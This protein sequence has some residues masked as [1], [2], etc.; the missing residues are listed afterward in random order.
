MSGVLQ[1]GSNWKR[2]RTRSGT[3][4]LICSLFFWP[5]ACRPPE[6]VRIAV[7]PQTE[8]TIHWD[9]AHAGAVFAADRAGASIYW[10][11]PTS[12]DDVQAQIALVNQVIDN[13]YQGLVLAPDQSLA[14]ITPVHRALAR[15]IPTVIIGSPLSIPAGR[16][17]FY[18]LN[19]DTEGGQIAAQRVADLLKGHGTVAVLGI[20]PNIAGIMIRARSF[21]QYLA[22]NFPEIHIVDKRIGTFNVAHEHQEAEDTLKANPNLDVIVALMGATI[23]GTLSALGAR[24]D[25]HS[26]KVIGF[27]FSP[28]LPSSNQQKYLDS[29]IQ[30]DTRA[31]GEQAVD[32]IHARLLGQTVPPILHVHPKLITPENINTPEVQLM[33]SADWKYG[34]WHWSSSQ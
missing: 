19:D 14:L 6:Q 4:G 26:I 9:P 18:I 31:M 5:T 32:L 2:R 12:E 3:A 1:F 10:N 24:P 28:L 30:E 29:V 11:A 34:R 25:N 16:N 21:E 17:L 7:I 15:G 27:D 23:D 20:N 33:F 22:Q 13:K 8:G